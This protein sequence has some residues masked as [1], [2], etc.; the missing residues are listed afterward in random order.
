M[1]QTRPEP[2]PGY[3]ALVIIDM[4]NALDFEGGEALRGSAEA[5]VAPI[6][7]LRTAADAAGMPVIYVNDNNGAWHS[8]RDRLIE[9][10]L[11]KDGP[12]RA[13]TERL[14]P[15]DDDYFIIKP[16]FSGFYATNLPVLLPQ[17]GVRRLILTGVAADICVL[18]TAADAHMREYGLWV[19]C[20]AVAGNHDERTRW[21]L[22]IMKNSMAAEICP[23]TQLALEDWIARERRASPSGGE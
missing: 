21:A 15:R 13:L 2:A 7:A 3:G 10:A 12:G 19:P 1:T 6:L 16:Q 5:A 22:E 20:D 4:V 18:F 17:L 14:R 11:A 9:D 23:T 8:E